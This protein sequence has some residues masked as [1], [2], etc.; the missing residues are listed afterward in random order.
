MS[1][2]Q[3][4]CKLGSFCSCA[5]LSRM[6]ACRL[7]FSTLGLM[8]GQSADWPE[9]MICPSGQG[10]IKLAQQERVVRCQTGQQ[11]QLPQCQL[12]CAEPLK[13]AYGAQGQGLVPISSVPA[14]ATGGYPGRHSRICGTNTAPERTAGDSA[15]G[16]GS[17]A[18]VPLLRPPLLEGGLSDPHM[19]VGAVCASCCR[20][21]EPGVRPPPPL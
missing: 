14:S 3:P 7:L 6:R 9:H 17:Q 8:H 5:D 2:S 12:L 11:L 10:V 21:T 19:H 1:H 18:H 15:G 4:A 13:G 16:D 20:D